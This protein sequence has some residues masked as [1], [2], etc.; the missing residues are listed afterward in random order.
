MIRPD[1]LFILC[2]FLIIFSQCQNKRRSRAAFIKRALVE[3][4]A[5]AV[6]FFHDAEMVRRIVLY[7]EPR[8]FGSFR[9]FDCPPT[10]T[11]SRRA[12][13]NLFAEY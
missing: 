13:V 5:R 11:P 2:N 4:Y 7:P 9:T 6:I 1:L 12:G 8:S 3:P 10:Y